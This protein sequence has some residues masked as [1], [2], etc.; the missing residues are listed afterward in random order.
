[1]SKHCLVGKK[2]FWNTILYRAPLE[3]VFYLVGPY[4][5]LSIDKDAL[6]SIS[7]SVLRL[8]R[9]IDSKGIRVSQLR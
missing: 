7:F 1:M 5:L 3:K 9:I 4:S 2:L 8:T 6:F